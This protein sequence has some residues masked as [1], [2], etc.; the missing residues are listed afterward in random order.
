M[1]LNAFT[2]FFLL[3]P[4]LPLL[5]TVETILVVSGAIV[6]VS[7]ATVIVLLIA[8][9][10]W[11]GTMKIIRSQ[12]L[13]LRSRTFVESSKALG[14][15]NFRIMMRHILPNLAGILFA[16][17]AYDVPGVIL[18]ESGLDFLGLGIRS[19]PTWGNMLGY[20]TTAASTAN[21]FAWWWVLPP[22]IGIV[23]L[24][25]GFFYFGSA[26]LD[27]LSPYRLRGE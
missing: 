26:L 25:L 22:G 15:G 4:G 19:F 2:D 5:I 6:R 9:L 1:S 10:S 23:V 8:L 7:L 13:S 21:S 27:V 24:S 20:A 11:P 17:L 18:A 14:A 3:L 16:Q 12:T